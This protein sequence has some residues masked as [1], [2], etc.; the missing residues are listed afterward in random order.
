[1]KLNFVEK[2]AGSVLFTGY[3]P[4][5]P[6][7]VSSIVAFAVYLVP[8]FEN[9]A[10]MILIISVLTVW[11]IKLGD[12]FEKQYGKDPAQ[13]T[14]DE[15]VGTWISLLFVPKV[16]WIL[17]VDFVLWRLTDIIKPFPARTFEKLKGGKGIMFDDIVSGAYSLIIIHIFISFL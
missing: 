13:C 8:G 10:F 16:Y 2:L 17:A 6:G 12:K 1:M 11:G 15:F 9:P 4:V 3:F 5:A 7:T 14:I